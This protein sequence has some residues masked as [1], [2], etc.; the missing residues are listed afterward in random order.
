MRVVAGSTSASVDCG[1][2]PPARM[3][4]RVPACPGQLFSSWLIILLGTVQS[5]VPFSPSRSLRPF[6]AF[7]QTASVAC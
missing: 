4:L 5:T 6:A 2:V 3:F 7:L 1:H